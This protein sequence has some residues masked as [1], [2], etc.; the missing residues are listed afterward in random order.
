MLFPV[1]S[2]SLL[3]VWLF[4]ESQSVMYKSWPGLYMIHTLQWWILSMM[5]SI[6]RDSM[7]TC[8]VLPLMAYGQRWHIFPSWSNSDGTFL[9]Y[10]VSPGLHILCCCSSNQCLIGFCWQTRSGVILHCLV[11]HQTCNS[12]HPLPVLIWPQ[13]WNQMHQSPGIGV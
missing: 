2:W 10:V 8:W 1:I 3:P 12:C 9:V 7:V 4:E 5:H 11:L 13:G 6:H